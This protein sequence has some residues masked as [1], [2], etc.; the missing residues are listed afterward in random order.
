MTVKQFESL[1]KDCIHNQTWCTFHCV[2]VSARKYMKNIHNERIYNNYNNL[3]LGLKTPKMFFHSNSEFLLSTVSPISN[4]STQFAERLEMH[5]FRE[6]QHNKINAN[7]IDLEILQ[8]VLFV[9]YVR[10]HL[11]TNSNKCI[12][13]QSK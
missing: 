4:M 13:Q 11:A 7:P 5:L 1:I 12:A 3:K 9:L 8:K 10:F 2:L 6:L